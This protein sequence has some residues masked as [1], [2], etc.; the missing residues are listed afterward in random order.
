MNC[1]D[2]ETRRQAS[3]K[4]CRALGVGTVCSLAFYAVTGMGW[5]A[6]IMGPQDVGRVLLLAVLHLGGLAAWWLS[7]DG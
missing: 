1:N 7:I 2:C 4:V 5:W 6:P 3:K